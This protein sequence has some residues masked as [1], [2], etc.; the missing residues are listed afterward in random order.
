MRN[1]PS[2]QTKNTKKQISD[3][4]KA[5]EQGMFKSRPFVMQQLTAEN[6]LQSNLHTSLRQTEHYGHNLN[7]MQPTKVLDTTAVQPKMGTGQPKQLAKR[8][9]N[10]LGLTVNTRREASGFVNPSHQHANMRPLF[11]KAAVSPVNSTRPLN[12]WLY[13]PSRRFY[14][15]T[16]T[17]TQPPGITQG[18]SNTVMGHNPDAVSRWNDYGHQQPR[19]D[20][21]TENRRAS[22]YHGLED[23]ASSNA[24]G[25]GTKERYLSPSPTIGSHP[26]YFDV[27]HPDFNPRNPWSDHFR[28]PDGNGGYQHTSVPQPRGQ[29][30]KRT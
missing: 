12:E 10:P 7:Q 1:Q 26:S 11:E 24:S 19:T 27:T 21:F 8:P 22:L 18:H 17:H 15:H 28:Q 30:R 6:S 16:P 20:N 14:T 9:K 4:F 13:S 29:K 2:T 3:F 5:P 25:G 23:R